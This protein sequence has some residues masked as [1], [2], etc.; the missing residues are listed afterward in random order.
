MTE[1]IM[2]YNHECRGNLDWCC[3]EHKEC[4]N[5]KQCSFYQQYRDFLRQK[6]CECFIKSA[7]IYSASRE[8]LNSMLDKC[9]Q[10]CPKYYRCDLVAEMNDKLKEMDGE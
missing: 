7:E 4:T 8:E 1:E 5:H 2:C 10:N 9:E 6:G 3:L